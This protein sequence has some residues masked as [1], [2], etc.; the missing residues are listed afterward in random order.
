MHLYTST[1]PQCFK[2]FKKIKGCLHSGPHLF[3]T[4]AFPEHLPCFIPFIRASGWLGGLPTGA[5]LP[6]R[7]PS[8]TTPA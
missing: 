7:V 8:P 6:I 4:Q 2:S 1:I 5:T 3:I